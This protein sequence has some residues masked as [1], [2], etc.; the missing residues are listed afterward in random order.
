MNINYFLSLGVK[1]QCAFS[2]IHCILPLPVFM[3]MNGR[4]VVRLKSRCIFRIGPKLAPR[5]DCLSF[6][7]TL[8]RN[9]EKEEKA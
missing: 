6:S 4:F 2:M 5:V 9:I 1:R 8:G 3:G 7:Y